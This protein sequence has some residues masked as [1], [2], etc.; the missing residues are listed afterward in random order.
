MRDVARTAARRNDRGKIR[1][2]REPNKACAS[3]VLKIVFDRARRTACERSPRPIR[4]RAYR[5]RIECRANVIASC[6]TVSCMKA[7]GFC[8]RRPCELHDSRSLIESH[9]KKQWA[10]FDRDLKDHLPIMLSI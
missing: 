7:R 1:S 4:G 9:A 10:A 5:E 2:C 3:F 6:V 8:R